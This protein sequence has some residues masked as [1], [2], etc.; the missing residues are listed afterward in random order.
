MLSKTDRILPRSKNEEDDEEEMEMDQE[1]E[2]KVVEEQSVFE[3]IVVW[4]HEAVMD[5]GDPYVRGVEEWIG[6]AEA[7]SF[8]GYGGWER[9]RERVVLIGGRFIRTIRT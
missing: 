9:G 7:V 4:G 6:F 2:I 1:V 8:H 5:E 3:E